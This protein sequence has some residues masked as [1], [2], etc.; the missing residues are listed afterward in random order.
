MFHLGCPV[1]VGHKW[2]LT[3]WLYADDQVTSNLFFVVVSNTKDS[4]S[5][6]HPDL[7][8]FPYSGHIVVTLVPLL[9]LLCLATEVFSQAG[10]G[11]PVV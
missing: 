1:L 4:Q 8:P 7:P 2:V 3:K 5:A 6:T 11:G 10:H 9:F